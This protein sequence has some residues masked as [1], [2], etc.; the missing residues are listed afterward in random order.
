M[1]YFMTSVT[2]LKKQNVI[3]FALMSFKEIHF[4]ILPHAWLKPQTEIKRCFKKINQVV[5]IY[6]KGQATLVVLNQLYY[7]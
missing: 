4:F 5:G 7:K 2:S 1:F 3:I 6:Q